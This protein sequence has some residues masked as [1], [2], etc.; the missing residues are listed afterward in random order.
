MIDL[1]NRS[2]ELSIFTKDDID[3]IKKE[4]YNL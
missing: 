1:E 4:K 3:K 2:L